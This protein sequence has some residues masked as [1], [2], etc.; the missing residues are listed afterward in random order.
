MATT[1]QE[2][3]RRA[4]K[5]SARVLLVYLLEQLSEPSTARG[6]VSL[7]ILAGGWTVEPEHMERWLLISVTVSALMKAVLPDRWFK[8]PKPKPKTDAVVT[9]SSDNT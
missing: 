2:N 6:L 3:T 5:K 1:K 9:K 8:K 7:A 4:A